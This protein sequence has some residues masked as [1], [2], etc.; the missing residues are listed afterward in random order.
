MSAKSPRARSTRAMRLLKRYPML[1]TVPESERPAV[2]RAAL[3]NPVLLVALVGVCFLLLPPYFKFAHELLDILHETNPL[4]LASK[5][6]GTVL[7]PCLV[8][9]PLLTRFVVPVFIRRQMKKRGYGTQ[10]DSES[11]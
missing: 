2:V 7:A 10:A 11:L 3:L 5:T 9:V 6:G 4:L 8:I 1:E